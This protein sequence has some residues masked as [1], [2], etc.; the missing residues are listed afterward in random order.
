MSV[1]KHNNWWQGWL[2]TT[3]HEG[4]YNYREC[5]PDLHMEHL[6]TVAQTNEWIS[7][8][9]GPPP[10]F[11]MFDVEADPTQSG[12]VDLVQMAIGR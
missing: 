11:V 10:R 7:R 4:K 2:D 12:Q 6:T 5:T 3:F 9:F 1:I 8:C